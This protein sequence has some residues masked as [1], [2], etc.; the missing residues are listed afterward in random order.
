MWC[1]GGL[2]STII[3]GTLD[4]NNQCLGHERSRDVEMLDLFHMN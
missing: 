3:L 4:S 2:C 1:V